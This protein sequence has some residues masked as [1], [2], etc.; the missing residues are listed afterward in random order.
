MILDLK[1]DFEIAIAAAVE[2]VIKN[3]KQNEL[4]QY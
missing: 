3:A 2:H 1:N 4:L